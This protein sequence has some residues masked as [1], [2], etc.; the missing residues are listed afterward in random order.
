[1]TLEEIKLKLFVKN[2]I[3]MKIHTDYTKIIVILFFLGYSTDRIFMET[4]MQ[5][6]SVFYRDK[7]KSRRELLKLPVNNVI[8]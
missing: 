2:I 5:A 3:K 8:K 4:I 7:K 6:Y 1:M